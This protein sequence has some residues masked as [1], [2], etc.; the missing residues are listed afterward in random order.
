MKIKEIL[1]D[2]SDY[3]KEAKSSESKKRR[4]VEEL[5]VQVNK[6][7]VEIIL[8][9]IFEVQED[10]QQAGFWNQLNVG[11]SSVLDSGK[12]NIRNAELFFYPERIQQLPFKTAALEKTYRA[13]FEPTADLRKITM[14]IHFPQRLSPIE[15]DRSQIVPIEEVNTPMVDRFMEEFIIG[16]IELYKSD[17]VLL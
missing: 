10:L 9:S 4:H 11:Q 6:C 15:D 16:S 5:L 13:S 3:S 1:N 2:F 14:Q 12:P 17:R 8:P 7:F